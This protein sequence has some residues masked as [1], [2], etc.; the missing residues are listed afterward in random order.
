M[1]SKRGIRLL[2]GVAVAA[3][4]IAGSVGTAAAAEAPGWCKKIANGLYCAEPEAA[5]PD[6]CGTKQ[7]SVALADGFADNGWRQQTT[8]AGIN[9]ASRCP[10][11]T[12]LDAHRRPGQHAKGDLRPARPG[13]ER[14][15]RD[16]RIPRRRPGDAADHPGRVQTGQF[17]RPVPCQ[18]RRQGR[19]GLHG[20]RRHRLQE[21][22]RRL[23][24]PGWRR[25]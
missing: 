6:F 11:V 5:P 17:R 2:S 24:A 9:E 8:A 19:C 22:W 7:I 3:M 15:Q 20:L 12:S 4:A 21:R 10:N 23:G 25:R 16:R 18:G 14:R 1:T 13:R